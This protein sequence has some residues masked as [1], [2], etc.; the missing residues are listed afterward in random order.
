MKRTRDILAALMAAAA[1]SSCSKL[2]LDRPGEADVIGY[3][4]VTSNPVKSTSAYN[5]GTF[6]S[7]AYALSS[8]QNW[9]SDAASAT[10]EFGPEEVKWNGSYWS[11]D[12]KRYWPSDKKLTFF[13]YA[14]ATLQNSGVN[15]ESDGVAAN[16]WD[17]LGSHKDKTF[18][19]ADIAKDKTKNEA[20]AGYTGVPT[21]FRHK[22]CKLTFRVAA[23]DLVEE[24]TEVYLLKATLNGF[25]SKA[26]YT[27]GGTSSESWS[28]LSN[29]Q[30][31][32]VLFESSGADDGKL[33]SDYKSKEW[34]MIPQSTSG[35]TL[36]INYR[37]KYGSTTKDDSATLS[38]ADD[39]R[40]GAWGMGQHITY[41]L[42]I[43]A[44]RI[45]ILFDGSSDAWVATGEGGIIEIK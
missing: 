36:T 30:K 33:T 43:G 3:N 12:K 45:P 44:G 4:V 9:D 18:L 11:T 34:I 42:K 1:L 24:G 23:S 13:S 29:Q 41:S 38:L 2:T 35:I 8:S 27:K 6:M 20:Y 25:Y 15:I 14:P 17:A 19:V 22:L 7:S 28:G 26:D 40:S 31:V 32:Y 39:F 5:Y 16:G 21:H 37:T 10:L